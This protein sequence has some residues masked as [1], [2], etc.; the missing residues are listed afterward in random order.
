MEAAGVVTRVLRPLLP[1]AGR[2]IVL[3][4]AA[5]APARGGFASISAPSSSPSGGGGGGRFSAGGRGGGGGGG[6]DDSGA[7]AAAAAAAVAALGEAEQ[8]DA[9][10]DAIVLHVGVT[11]ARAHATVGCY[12]ATI[13]VRF[14]WVMLALPCSLAG[15]D[16]RRMRCQGQADPREPGT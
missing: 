2:P 13:L 1:A 11:L 5:M 9:D 8:S 16:V 7:G 15:D 12:P 14:P 10:P 6:G 4:A 3:L